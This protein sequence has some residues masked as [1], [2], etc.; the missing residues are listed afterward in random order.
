MKGPKRMQLPRYVDIGSGVLGKIPEKLESMRIKGRFLVITGPS[1]TLSYGERIHGL[2]SSSS[3][4]DLSSVSGEKKRAMKSVT[5]L[6]RRERSDYILAVGGGKTIDVAKYAAWKAECEFISVPTVLSH[7]GI[8]SSRVSMPNSRGVASMDAVAP[9][10]IVMDSKVIANAP[11]RFLVSGCGD[12]VAKN[13]AVLDWELAYRLGRDD[14]SDYACALSL[15]SAKMV[16]DSADLIN[17][18]SEEGVRLVAKALMGSGVAMSI[19]GS[20]RPGS[21]SEHLFSHALDAVCPNCALHG[22]QVGL[23]SIMMMYLHGGDWKAMRDF[24]RRIGAPVTATELGIEEENIVKALT[25]AHRIRPDRYTILGETGLGEAA[26]RRI[27][28]R[29]EVL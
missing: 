22:E 24:L 12:T 10:A 3:D 28:R 21:G 8:A 5:D 27:A 17:S 23:G 14:K 26:A 2:M 6:L 13:T 4:V 18:R 15:M 19:A 9:I 16:M 7:D 25:N 29:T 20:S 11:Y 1:S